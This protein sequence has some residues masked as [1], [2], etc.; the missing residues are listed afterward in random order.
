MPCPGYPAATGAPL[1][2]GF[3]GRENV[4]EE[5]KRQAGVR[6]C[7]N[8]VFGSVCCPQLSRFC[9]SLL[10][11]L[12]VR[13]SV[14]LCFFSLRFC[15][16]PSVTDTRSGRGSL[17]GPVLS[18]P[19]WLAA[20]LQGQPLP[21]PPPPGTSALRAAS[22]LRLLLETG[23]QQPTRA[24]PTSRTPGFWTGTGGCR[25]TARRGGR[26]AAGRGGLP[27]SALGALGVPAVR[28]AE[29]SCGRAHQGPFAAAA[30]QRRPGARSSPELGVQAETAAVKPPDR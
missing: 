5:N 27:A 30:A 12:S 21:V 6:A 25:T 8:L 20:A 15:V 11:G 14:T 23:A 19:H 16:C 22:A 4:K 1:Q 3:A 2:A 28:S 26:G 29:P 13:L 9:V 7:L 17:S 10:I 24:G 18:G